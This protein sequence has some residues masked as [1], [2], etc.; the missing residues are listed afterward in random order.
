[1]EDPIE[2]NVFVTGILKQEEKEERNRKH[3]W[4]NNDWKFFKHDDN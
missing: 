2:L 1:M 4:N 3:S